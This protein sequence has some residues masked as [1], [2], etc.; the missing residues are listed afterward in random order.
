MNAAQ[1]VTATFVQFVLTTAVS[2]S[3]TVTGTGS[4]GQGTA[5]T[6]TTVIGPTTTTVYASAFG[7][8]AGALPATNVTAKLLADLPT[9]RT[10]VAATGL[11]PAVHD[12][13][14]SNNFTIQG[15]MSFD[16]ST[17][18]PANGPV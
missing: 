6:N 11:A 7:L 5:W 9:A 17:G 4:P 14:P 13:G 18:F 3:G 2:G 8:T 15:A 16:S 1:S 10:L 12:T